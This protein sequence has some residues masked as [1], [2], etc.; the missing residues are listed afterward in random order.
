MKKNSINNTLNNIKNNFSL[1]IDKV[2]PSIDILSVVFV[3]ILISVLASNKEIP[4]YSK[5]L[6]LLALIVLISCYSME[7][8]IIVVVIAIIFVVFQQCYKKNGNNKEKFHGNSHNDEK[9]SCGNGNN[10]SSCNG[11]H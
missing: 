2:S 4:E 6:F 9:R 1:K 7:I 8:G 11:N 5:I 3:I 10:I